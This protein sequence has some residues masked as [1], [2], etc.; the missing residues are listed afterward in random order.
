MIVRASTAS[1]PPNWPPCRT[2]RRILARARRAWH[3][4]PASRRPGLEFPISA[5]G[6]FQPQDL[7]Q[8]ALAGWW[9]LPRQAVKFLGTAPA[10]CTEGNAA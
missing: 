1:N 5:L 4:L 8:L 7:A 3:R 10:I 2:I 6:V 9:P